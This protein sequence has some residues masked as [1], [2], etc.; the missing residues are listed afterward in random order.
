MIMSLHARCRANGSLP[1]GG[2]VLDQPAYLMTLFDDIDNA[3]A[4]VRAE[5]AERGEDDA[6]RAQLSAG[7]TNGR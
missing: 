3:R 6:I 7:L 5:I 4:E 2:G 1:R